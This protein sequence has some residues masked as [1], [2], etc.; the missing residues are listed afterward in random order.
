MHGPINI[1]KTIY[2]NFF[3]LMDGVYVTSLLI[4]YL[5]PIRLTNRFSKHILFISQGVPVVN[6]YSDGL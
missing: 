5:Q 2:F 3:D 1:R 6:W 4:F